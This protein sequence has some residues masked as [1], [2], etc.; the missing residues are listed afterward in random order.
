MRLV[1]LLR[2]GKLK[3]GLDYH[4]YQQKHTLSVFHVQYIDAGTHPG[5]SVKWLSLRDPHN[6]QRDSQST[7]V[8]EERWL[9]RCNSRGR[10]FELVL[11]K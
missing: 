6:C 4:H 2:S 3:F 9:Q 1:V 11:L 5:G 10:A 7:E 8:S